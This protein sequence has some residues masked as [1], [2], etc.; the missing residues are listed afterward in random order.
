M[1]NA[2]AQLV[3]ISKEDFQKCF[4]QWKDHWVKCVWSHKGTTLKE[5]RIE[6]QQVSYFF[7]LAYGQILFEQTSYTHHILAKNLAG[8]WQQ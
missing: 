4:Q 3:A 1:K 8:E 6:S 2:T 5:I 7:P